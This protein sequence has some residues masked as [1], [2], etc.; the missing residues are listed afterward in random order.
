MPNLPGP[1][2]TEALAV[3]SNDCGRLQDECPKFPVLPRGRELGP[4][5]SIRRRQ[6]GPLHGALQKSDLVAQR[7]NLQLEHSTAPKEGRQ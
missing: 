3:P 5:E 2:Q 1:E 6:F 4:Q 7:E